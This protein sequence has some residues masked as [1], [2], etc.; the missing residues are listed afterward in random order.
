[1]AFLPVLRDPRLYRAHYRLFFSGTGLLD[2]TQVVRQ[3][4]RHSF[5]DNDWHAFLRPRLFGTALQVQFHVPTQPTRHLYPSGFL[6]PWLG[7]L[8]RHCRNE[9]GAHV[10][11]LPTLADRPS[12]SANSRRSRIV[13]RASVLVSIL[14]VACLVL[15]QVQIRVLL[16]GIGG[17]SPKRPRSIISYELTLSTR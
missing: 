15:T 3:G 8:L 13:K 7:L 17:D 11:S 2:Q 1:M 14:Y 12:I 10:R 9:S 16:I 4:D 6:R 5:P